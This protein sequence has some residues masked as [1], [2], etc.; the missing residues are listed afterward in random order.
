MP[1]AKRTVLI[2]RCSEGG[3]EA[4]LAIAFHEAGLRVIA[5]ARTPSKMPFLDGTGIE[6]LSLDVQSEASIQECVSKLSSLDILVNNAGMGAFESAVRRLPYTS[7]GSVR[8]EYLGSS[9]YDACVPLLLTSEQAMIVNN[10]SSKSKNAGPC[11]NK[12]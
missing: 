12:I 5:P 9:R 8:A 1:T 2:T 10:T 4:A 3:I 7:R 6:R 11:N